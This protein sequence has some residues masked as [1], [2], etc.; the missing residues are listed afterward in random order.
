MPY[1]KMTVTA[2]KD[3]YTYKYHSARYG[4]KC[5]RGGNIKP[6]PKEQRKINK[7]IAERKRQWTASANF[8]KDDWYV[9]LTYRR[10][11]RP[12]SNAAAHAVLMNIIAK[13]R[14]KLKRQGVP[15]Y[16]MCSTETGEK[17]A[18][19]HHLIIKNNFNIGMLLELW[20][21]GRIDTVSIYTDSMAVLGGYLTKDADSGKHANKKAARKREAIFSSS[22][23]LKKPKIRK[24]IIKAIT[25]SE[26]PVPKKDCYI[27]HEYSGIQSIAG[28]LYQEYIQTHAAPSEITE[29]RLVFKAT[30][31]EEVYNP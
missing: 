21:H 23:N 15:L 5:D 31:A 2:G 30:G 3:E 11:E 17:G 12:E 16:Y 13:L 22:R 1:I 8:G 24:Q 14:R 29:S 10:N 26:I 9:T 27:I 25:F 7:R 4:K 6:T 19:H 28:Y 20:K 18:V